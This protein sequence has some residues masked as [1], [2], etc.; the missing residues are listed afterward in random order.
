LKV[1][2]PRKNKV[3]GNRRKFHSEEMNDLH[4]SPNIIRIQNEGTPNGL[5][6]RNMWIEDK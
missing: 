1:L 6:R 2:W 3:T 5:D 4:S